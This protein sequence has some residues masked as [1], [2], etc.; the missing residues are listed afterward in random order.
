MYLTK[1]MVRNA[2]QLQSLQDLPESVPDTIARVGETPLEGVELFDPDV[3]SP[4][5]IVDALAAADLEAVG[6][7]VRVDRLEDDLDDVVATY[8]AIGCRRL[9]VPIYDESAFASPDGVADAARRL[10]SISERLDDEGF[11]LLYH[12]HS[13]EFSSL[14]GRTAFDAL[15]EAT[16]GHL[17]LELDTGLATFGGADPVEVLSRYRDRTPMIHLTDAVP[18]R[19]TTKQVELGAGEL[20]VEACVA[21]AQDAGVE[22]MIYEHGMTSDPLDSLT[23]AAT[24]L[25][26]L[27]QGGGQRSDP[28]STHD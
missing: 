2:I 15:L 27:T 9:V 10:S 18:G 28:L 3:E 8:D 22:W 14:D 24:K 1:R 12:N 19:E 21:T 17:D 26:A 23:H 7:H 6:A 16:D 25:P 13:Y 4:S 20:D 5:A 11:E